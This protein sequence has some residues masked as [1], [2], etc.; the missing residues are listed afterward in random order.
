MNVKKYI[1]PGIVIIA[2]GFLIFV[3]ARIPLGPLAIDIVERVTSVKISYSEIDGSILRGYTIEH[4]CIRFSDSDSICGQKADIHY[5]FV[6]SLLRLPSVFEITLIEPHIFITQKKSPTSQKGDRIS[7]PALSTGIRLNIKNGSVNYYHAKLVRFENISG[8]VFVDLIGS[9]LYLNTMNLSVR[10][11][12]VPVEIQSMNIEA[13]ITNETADIQ[14]L[15]AKGK[16][17]TIKGSGTYQ[18]DKQEGEFQINNANLDL[19]A[20]GIYQGTIDFSGG[21]R[22]ID[23]K[24]HPQLKGTA[25]NVDPVETCLFETNTFGDTIYINVFDGML[26]KGEV[27][28]QL[29]ILNLELYEIDANFKHIDLGAVLDIEH[30]LNIDGYMAYR[31]GTF[32]GFLSS[33]P[34]QG[35]GI[36]SLFVR[37]QL[38]GDSIYIDT[39][40]VKEEYPVLQATGRLSPGCDVHIQVQELSIERFSQFISF[41]DT[42]FTGIVSGTCHLI[43]ESKHFNDLR[44]TSSLSGRDFVISDITIDEA[45]IMSE[46][47]C[48]HGHSNKIECYLLNPAYKGRKIDSIHVMIDS[49]DYLVSAK[50]NG[51]HLRAQGTLEKD[52]T[53]TITS[54]SLKYHGI[55]IQ[56]NEP[57]LFDIP[58]QTISDF[59]LS[60]AGG[61]LRGSMIPISLDLTDADLEMISTLLGLPDPIHGSLDCRIRRNRIFI[62]GQ[63]IDFIGLSQGTVQLK[64]SIDHDILLVEDLLIKDST[65]HLTGQAQLSPEGF[66]ISTTFDNVGLWVLPFLK[67]FMS[68]PDGRVSGTLGLAGTVEDY[69]FSGTVTLSNGSFFIEPL[70]ARFDSIQ[71]EVQFLEN[72]IMFKSGQGLVSRMSRFAPAGTQYGI[73]YAGGLITLGPKFKVKS[74]HYDFSFKNAPLQFMPFAYGIGN[75]NV[76]LGVKND[77]TY[78][79]GS[80]TIKQA[81]VPLEFGQVIEE[82]TSGTHEAWTMNIKIRGERN[83]WLRNRDADIEFG[84]ELYLIK[85]RG[86]LYL[87]GRLTTHRGNYYWLN[88]M[89]SIT[90]GQITFLPQEPVQAELDIWAKM[91][92]RDRDPTTGTPITIKLHM[93]GTITEPIFEFFSDPPYYTE[94]DIVTYLNLNITW[95]ELESMKRGDFVRTVLPHS[96]L[97]WLESDVSRRIRQYT[98][99][100]YFRIETPFFENESSTRLTVG[101]YISRRLFISYTY[102][103]TSFENEFNVEYFIDDKNEILVRRDEEGDYS[104]QY[105]YR[106]RF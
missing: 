87:T 50:L 32:Q 60:F 75:G 7:L 95:S 59:N 5:R 13:R 52:L 41:P 86:P 78:Y 88:H 48:F 98:G 104:V 14:S 1:A 8:L 39:L 68:E 35:I 73:A 17:F 38:R 37:G 57:V 94:Q 53:G 10:S 45:R 91:D 100:D 55:D 4:Y 49:D 69:E 82:D 22:I 54:L 101:K 105:Q 83:I 15:R 30:I 97:S 62:I 58:N 71:G 76:S 16:G 72:R 96:L 27:F 106:I 34:E 51:D 81:I 56:N 42:A 67:E 36:E 99:L 80:I 26:Y 89:L 3:L 18:I 9:V 103:I 25:Y 6:P 102:D 84:G 70:A 46:D 28:A 90:E 79:N 40:L 85:E 12:D 93:F 31:Q 47:F 21:I 64:G 20:L 44:I 92:T 43:C 33:P 24:I 61:T 77:T 74:V 65:Q 23:G 63:N 29:K 11:P 2:L 66:K 19:K